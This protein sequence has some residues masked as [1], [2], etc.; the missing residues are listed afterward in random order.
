METKARNP[1]WLRDEL[2]IAL[3]FYLRHAPTIPGKKSKEIAE[4]GDSL[5]RLRMSLGGETSATLRNRNAVYMKLMNFKRL[6]PNYEGK[7]LQRGNRDEEIV[8]NRYV[9]RSSELDR[10]TTTISALVS[11]VGSGL[12]KEAIE[13]EEEAEEGRILTRAHRYRE[14][15]G[16]F[17][18]RK[19]EGVLRKQGELRCE[20]CGFD[21]AAMYGGHGTAFIECHHATPLS[22][23]GVGEKTK[24]SDLRLLCSNCHR[25]IHRRRPWLS[26]EELQG[27]V[28][29]RRRAVGALEG[30]VAG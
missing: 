25:M 15:D 12:S 30:K 14:R 27:M 13:E 9:S 21:F 16:K 20:A 11:S 17:V 19:K 26:V 18:K 22:Q 10:V 3:E 29:S 28:A 23:L 24:V 7:G 4:L 5:N 1:R 8:W 2:I 6:D